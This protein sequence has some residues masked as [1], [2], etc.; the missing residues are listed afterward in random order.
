MALTEELAHKIA[1]DIKGEDNPTVFLDPATIMAIIGIIVQIV[2]MYRECKKSPAEAKAHMADI[3]GWGGWWSRRKLWRAAKN[4]V[5]E[6]DS[7]VSVEEVYEGLLRHA[8]KVTISDMTQLYM[9]NP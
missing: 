9:E 7:S 6:N 5:R 3:D 8:K 1:A 4:Y 2:K